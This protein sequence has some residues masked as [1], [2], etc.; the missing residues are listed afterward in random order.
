MSEYAYTQQLLAYLI[1]G[2]ETTSTAIRWGIKFLTDDQRA[3]SNLRTALRAAYPEAVSERRPP[4]L[5]EILKTS[6]PYLDAVIEENLRCGKALPMTMREALVDT[7]VL[8]KLIPKGTSVVLMGNGPGLTIP[9][10]SIPFDEDKYTRSE[11]AKEYMSKYGRFDDV[12]IET[13][14]P[15]RWLKAATNDDGTPGQLEFDP[16]AGPIFAF[17]LGPRACFG[18]KLAYLKMRVFFT[19]LF[20]KYK[21]DVIPKELAGHEE[22]LFLTRAPTNVFVRLEKV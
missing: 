14:Y 9:S 11:T 10:T 18:R 13:Y 19:L 17:G 21:F 6:V 12:G 1:A 5:A 4:N 20:L 16:N 7:Q 22:T 8:G 15:E 2:H 3:Q